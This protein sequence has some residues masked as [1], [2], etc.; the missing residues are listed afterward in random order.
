MSIDARENLTN[1]KKVQS[2]GTGKKQISEY[3]MKS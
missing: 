2:K 3:Q 1:H